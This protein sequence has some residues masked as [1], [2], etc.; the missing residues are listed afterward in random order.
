MFEKCLIKI[1]K[2]PPTQLKR[3]QRRK[4]KS[5]SSHFYL[6]FIYCNYS[7]LI[8]NNKYNFILLKRFEFEIL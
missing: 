1:R 6:R 2:K 8:L 5:N 7:L 4:K 3:Y